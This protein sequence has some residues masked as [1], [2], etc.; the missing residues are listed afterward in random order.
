MLEDGQFPL[1]S[2]QDARALWDLMLYRRTRAVLLFQFGSRFCFISILQIFWGLLFMEKLIATQK[3]P[4][5]SLGFSKIH[6]V[7]IKLNIKKVGKC[8]GFNR[9]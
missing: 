1:I 8:R 9:K 5:A 2:I 4:Q 3:H 7:E 6:K